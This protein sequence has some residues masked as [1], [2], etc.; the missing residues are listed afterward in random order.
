M[1]DESMTN[2]SHRVALAEIVLLPLENED[3]D[4]ETLSTVEEVTTQVWNE[5]SSMQGYI[6]RCHI[7]CYVMMRS[8]K[9]L[10]P[11]RT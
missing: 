7:D 9:A 6:S 11:V 3:D 4:F 10:K 8:G 2:T 1:S 5:T